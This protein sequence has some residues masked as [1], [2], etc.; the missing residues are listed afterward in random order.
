MSDKNRDLLFIYQNKFLHNK[1]VKSIEFINS[2]FS[3]K[4]CITILLHLHQ[5]RCAA[6]GMMRQDERDGKMA[7]R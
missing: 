6:G 7:R 4:I 2:Q 1:T 5:V 3:I